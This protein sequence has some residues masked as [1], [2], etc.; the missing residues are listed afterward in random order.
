M[1]TI[2]TVSF[3]YANFLMMF[4]DGMLAC[5]HYQQNVY[6][7]FLSFH[8]TSD[9]N[10]TY[11]MFQTIN[12]PN[13]LIFNQA[14]III[15]MSPHCSITAYIVVIIMNFFLFHLFINTNWSYQIEKYLNYQGQMETVVDTIE[16]EKK[17][18]VTFE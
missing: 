14:T 17:M 9:A 11:V 5:D 16:K 18:C 6:F 13:G 7:F 15:K 8:L 3:S 12:L 1:K 2:S 10:V 4:H